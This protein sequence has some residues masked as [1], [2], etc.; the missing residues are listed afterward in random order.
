MYNENFI[1]NKRDPQYTRNILREQ[2]HQE[3]E[4]L[5]M[6]ANKVEE[7]WLSNTAI[8]SYKVLEHFNIK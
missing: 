6:Q 5:W 7:Q 1:I 4:Q 8:R 2:Q 3:Q